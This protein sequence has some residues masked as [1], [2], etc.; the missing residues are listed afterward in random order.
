MEGQRIDYAAELNAEQQAAVTAPD[1]PVL[2]IAAAGT[3][4]TRTLVYRVAYLVEGGHDPNSI[5]LLTFTNRAAQE[6]LERARGLVGGAVSGL[7]GGTFHHMAN[8]LLRRHAAA[9][10]Y[11]SDY[12]IL[13]SDDAR[14]LVR[15]CSQDLKLTDK[16][17]PKPDVLL[18]LFGLA[19]ST[20]QPVVA[21]AEDRFEYSK[22]EPDD[23]VAV[24]EAYEERKR[25]LNAMDFDDL[26][27]NGLRLL[28]SNPDLCER[29][30]QQFGHILV[31]EYQD[32]NPVQAHWV[33]LLTGP[34]GNVLVVGDDFQSIYSW[35]GAD[36]RNIITFPERYP[37]AHVYYLVTN[38]RSVPEILHMANACIAGNPKQFQKTLQAVREPHER[39][40]CVA[41]QDGHHQADFIIQEARRLRAEG[42]RYSEMVVLY[43]AHYHAM[44]LQM[45]LSRDQTIPYV[46]TSGIRF[47]EQGHIKD[48]CALLRLLA[49]PGDELAFQRL[50]CLWKR[51]GPKTALKIWKGLGGR[52]DL[53]KDATRE[54]VAQGLPA[55]AREGWNTVEMIAADFDRHELAKDP[56]EIIHRFMAGFYEDYAR[57]TFENAERRLEDLNELMRYTTNFPT[58]D[59][60]LSEMALQTNLDAE[61]EVAAQQQEDVLRLSTVHQA[62]GLEWKVVFLCWVADGMFPTTRAVNESEEGLAEERRLFYVA[63]TRAKDALYLCVPRQRRGRDGTIQY[64]SPSAFIQE[65]SPDLMSVVAG[66]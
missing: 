11:Q 54:R 25:R 36:Y 37:N 55:P 48:V 14:R 60:F 50:C 18:S 26:L 53:R 52:C 47:F 61:A 41:L 40:H 33:D 39:P 51:L 38:Y 17:F 62:K 5:L 29:Y 31:D 24:H 19:A 43:R 49:N 66:G 34:G 30:R 1:G 42:Y 23:V 59:A 44:E 56:G 64:L 32:T 58:L 46:I 15:H 10:G 9:V 20:E 57:E 12:T 22:V 8:R 27:T 7:W 16:H 45:A 3:G 6:M 65:L 2:V 4:K 13:D 21:L 63:I 28:V 35:R